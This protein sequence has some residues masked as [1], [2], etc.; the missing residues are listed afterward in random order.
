L[1]SL[2]RRWVFPQS[3]PSALAESDNATELSTKRLSL[4]KQLNPKLR[5]VA[6]LWNKDDLGMSMRYEASA[7]VAQSVGVT[8]MPLGVPKPDDFNEAFAAMNRARAAGR[9]SHGVRRANH[10]QREARVR[11]RRRAETTCDLRVRL[12]RSRRYVAVTTDGQVL[13]DTS[14]Y[15]LAAPWENKASELEAIELV[16]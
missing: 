11:L 2:P 10:A 15:S 3:W 7:D 12:P 13:G 16:A 4:L 14:K 5:R 1:R 8:V 6:M 9:H